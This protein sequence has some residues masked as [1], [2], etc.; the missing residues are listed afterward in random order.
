M[1]QSVRV[2]IVCNIAFGEQITLN[3][4][5]RLISDSLSSDIQPIYQSTRAGDIKHSLADI[6]LAKEYLN[7][8]PAFNV[9]EGL[10]L[11]INRVIKTK[12]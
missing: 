8:Y 9:K 5:W 11:L 6:T 1:L 4:L 7:Y 10:D 12:S 2:P 3:S